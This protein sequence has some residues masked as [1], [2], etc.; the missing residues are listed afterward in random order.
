MTIDGIVTF[1]TLTEPYWLGE[2]SVSFEV[3][4]K[5][6]DPSAIFKKSLDLILSLEVQ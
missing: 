4:L 6:L 3:F 1:K 2:H 5:D